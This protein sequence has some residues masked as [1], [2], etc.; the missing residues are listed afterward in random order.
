[1]Q[2]DDRQKNY[3]GAVFFRCNNPPEPVFFPVLPWI[4]KMHE[5]EASG[6]DP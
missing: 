5:Q 2:F 1:M 6:V 4:R 3:S